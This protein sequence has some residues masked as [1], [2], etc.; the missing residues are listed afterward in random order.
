[1]LLVPIAYTLGA[2]HGITNEAIIG[3]FFIPIGLG[4]LLGAPIAGRISDKTVKKWRERRGAWYPEDR[5][6]ATLPG[7]LVF[8][9]LSV[10]LFGIFTKYVE[11]KFGIALCLACLF[12]NGLGVDFVFSPSAAYNIDILHSRSA[13]VMAAGAGFRGI[14][15]A[16]S[17]SLLL[18]MIETVGVVTTNSI[19]AVLAWIG[20]F[21]LWSVIRYGDRM[22]AYVDVGF[23]T[24]RDN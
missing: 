19:A 9:P 24:L 3:T 14:I 18:P 11:G 20:F 16:L 7:A 21:A 5:L 17:T 12:M 2:K 23:S 15:I 13:E 10:L 4:N 6:R 8:V 22:R 1:V